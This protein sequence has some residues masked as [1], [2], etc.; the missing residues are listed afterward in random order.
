MLVAGDFNPRP[1][2]RQLD[3]LGGKAIWTLSDP[4]RQ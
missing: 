4:A 2:E 1:V 3:L